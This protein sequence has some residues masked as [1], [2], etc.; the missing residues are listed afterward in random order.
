MPVHKRR[1][2]SKLKPLTPDFSKPV[3]DSKGEQIAQQQRVIDALR[4]NCGEYKRIIETLKQVLSETPS[5]I[6]ATFP[7]TAL[8]RPARKGQL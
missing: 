5:A 4:K 7:I 3:P 1:N 8:D 6:G 2:V